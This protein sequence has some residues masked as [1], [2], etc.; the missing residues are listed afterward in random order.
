MC[1]VQ[2]RSGWSRDDL[3]NR[4]PRAQLVE[5]LAEAIWAQRAAYAR[6]SA[7]LETVPELMD[8]SM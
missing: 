7:A 5:A 6:L 8:E 1:S 4:M 2:R 3:L